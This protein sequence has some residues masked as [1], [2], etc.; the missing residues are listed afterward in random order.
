MSAAMPQIEP[1]I[2]AAI[3]SAATN[4]LKQDGLAPTPSAS[5]SA[6][7]VSI[8]TAGTG[9]A[10]AANT[11]L[12]L[13]LVISDLIGGAVVALPAPLPPPPTLAVSWSPA[14]VWGTVEN[15][16]F[17]VKNASTGQP[18]AGAEIRVFN[19]RHTYFT[20]TT[21]SHGVYTT[22]VALTDTITYDNPKTGPNTVTG[23][24]PT[25]RVTASGYVGYQNEI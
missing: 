12:S 23:V 18:V 9:P 24:N 21:N 5:F 4:A 11:S 13:S 25:I 3:V 16:T 6:V 2:N 19:N 10:T 22:K 14:P 8:A 7:A 20:G 15:Y 17:T 1:A